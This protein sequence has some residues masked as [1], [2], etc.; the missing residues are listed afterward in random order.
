[1]SALT[2]L[3]EPIFRNRTSPHT[4]HT[5]H[6]TPTTH[7]ILEAHV[8]KLMKDDL[9]FVSITFPS[10]FARNNQLGFYNMLSHVEIVPADRPPRTHSVVSQNWIAQLEQ[11]HLVVSRRPYLGA[12]WY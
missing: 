3:S 1:V 9:L 12:G 6:V 8:Y 4:I 11:S 10:I 5:N 7:R 2:T